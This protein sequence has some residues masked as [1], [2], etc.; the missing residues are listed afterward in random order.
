M[1]PNN[2]RP[3]HQVEQ[4]RNEVRITMEHFHTWCTTSSTN[5]T[6]T[7]ATT[8]TVGT[9][10]YYFHNIPQLV[11]LQAS[12]SNTT[13]NT[14]TA[15]TTTTTTDT[16]T[17]NQEEDDDDDHD[18]NRGMIQDFEQKYTQPG[19]LPHATF[20]YTPLSTTTITATTTTTSIPAMSLWTSP[21]TSSTINATTTI[22]T[23][24]SPFPNQHETFSSSSSSSLSSSSL[25]SS[26][27]L[28]SQ[29]A[30]LLV[31]NCLQQPLFL[32][33]TTPTNQ[34][35]N[36]KSIGQRKLVQQ[37]QIG[38]EQVLTVWI[39]KLKLMQAVILEHQ[40]D[41]DNHND[42]NGNDDETNNDASYYYY[43]WIDGGFPESLW[44]S[45]EDQIVDTNHVWMR[46][47]ILRLDAMTKIEF[48]A[49]IILGT[50]QPLLRL[51]DLYLQSLPQVQQE[52]EEEE[53]QQQQQHE[54]S[55]P[56]TNTTT[57]TSTTKT[58]PPPPLCRDEE[59]VLTQLYHSNDEVRTNLT[60]KWKHWK[61]IEGPRR[62]RRQPNK[63]T[64]NPPAPPSFNNP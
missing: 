13:K 7:T 41:N 24:P 25:S 2:P 21:T 38:Y 8:T 60:R 5:T 42:N 50:A 58:K 31:E 64:K 23:E 4:F 10:L 34:K 22:T 14:T 62:R 1:I 35:R 30:H 47:S 51:I 3:N 48:S 46:D 26:S 39:S 54:G 32:T 59:G 52:E 44:K 33:S 57:F 18:H 36:D 15:T 12:Q 9:Q 19:W 61:K 6:N 16:S 43:A 29:Q 37:N 63:K 49:G 11:H 45:L 56:V 28:L 27:L 20:R 40:C 17:T 55:Q 53:Q